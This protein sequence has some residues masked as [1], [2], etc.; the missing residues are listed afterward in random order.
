MKSVTDIFLKYVS[1]DTQSSEESESYPSTEKQLLLGKYIAEELKEIGLSDVEMDKYGYVYAT[2]PATTDKKLPVIGFL[3]H[4]DTALELPGKDVKTQ[5]IEYQGGDVVLN[6]TLNIVMTEKEFPCLTRDHGKHLICTDGTTLLGAD[7]KAGCAEIVAMA[8]YFIAHPEIPHGKMRIAFTPDEEV[9]GG[10]KFFDIAKFGADYAYTADGEGTGSVN[11][12]NFNA[13]AAVVKVNGF[14]IHPGGSKNKMKNACLMAMEFNSLLPA[15]EIPAL[16]E[17]HEGFSHLGGMQGT[18][19]NAVLH[20]IIRDHDA[21][22]LERKKE[23]FRRAAEYMNYKYGEN[24]IE[25]TLKDSYRNMAEFI[26]PHPEILDLAY[27]AIKACGVTPVTTP[28][29]GGTD[30]ARLSADGL[31]CPN[32]GDGGHNCHGK[33]EYVATEDLEKCTEILIKMVE[34]SAK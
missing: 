12:E 9:G 17:D 30:G 31:P 8:Q 32:L 3:G 23:N 22:K 33:F 20:Y 1:F 29:R 25:L 7:D 11:Y 27:D 2:I 14:S 18:V 26:L 4:M 15:G 10:T 5:V 34:L 21:Q 28:V 16:T 19:E 6:P 13:S 24:T